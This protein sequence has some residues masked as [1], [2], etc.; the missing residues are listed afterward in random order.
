M[1]S[2]SWLHEQLG[3]APW[4]QVGN[5][6]KEISNLR[7]KVAHLAADKYNHGSVEW[8][9]EQLTALKQKILSRSQT[10]PYPGHDPAAGAKH[11]EM[12][13]EPPDY[14]LT[15]QVTT[16]KKDIMELQ[17]SVDSIQKQ[18]NRL[19]AH[20]GIS[21]TEEADQTETVGTDTATDLPPSSVEPAEDLDASGLIEPEPADTETDAE[22]SASF[23]P[24][25]GEV[26]ATP[27][28]KRRRLD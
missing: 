8:T 24:W 5:V 18:L 28:P 1:A 25:R 26:P 27:M 6:G 14:W 10:P 4:L 21:L 13:I 20:L 23:C 19:A 17:H 22:E 11:P 3:L 16:N 7:T 12:P 9:I 2:S 15:N